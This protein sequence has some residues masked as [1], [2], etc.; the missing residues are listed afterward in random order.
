MESRVKF[1]RDDAGV[2]Y[3][4]LD[5]DGVYP[6]LTEVHSGTNDASL[7]KHVPSVTVNGQ[8]VTAVIGE[9]IHP[10]ID[11]HFIEWIMLETD[12]GIYVKWLRPGVKPEAVFQ[13]AEGEIPVAVYEL[14]NIHGLWKKDL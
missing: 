13:M 6:F 11:I 12:R 10:M 4:Y 3:P 7:E 2:V 8:T 14:C 5:Q 9:V 1:Y